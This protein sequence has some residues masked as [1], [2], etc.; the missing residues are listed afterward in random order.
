M[1]CDGT[2][3]WEWVKKSGPVLRRL[4]TK[5]HDIFGQCRGPFVLSSEL[6]R[7]SMPPSLKRYAP[8]GIEVVENAN[9]CK[10]FLAQFF[11]GTTPTVLQH[12]VNAIYRP[13]FGKVWLSS[14]C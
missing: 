13:P 4:S 11:L 14:V 7:L 1:D 3:L 2:K 6:A 10:S 8:L 12:I 9:K 5:V